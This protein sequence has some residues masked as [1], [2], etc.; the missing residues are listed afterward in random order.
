MAYQHLKHVCVEIYRRWLDQT[1]DAEQMVTID[2]SWEIDWMIYP[3]PR[4][5]MRSTLHCF[6]SVRV[7]QF[8]FTE[9]IMSPRISFITPR[10]F[11]ISRK[12][13]KTQKIRLIYSSTS[14][15][16]QVIKVNIY[17]Y[18]Y[19]MVDVET[20]KQPFWQIY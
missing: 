3:F 7:C 15:A 1:Y 5:L 12:V 20:P 16:R 9:S 2:L 13:I 11:L 17:I 19:I 18:I 10:I 14:P 8:A 6:R 4:F